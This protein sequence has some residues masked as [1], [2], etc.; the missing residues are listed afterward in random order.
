MNKPKY[1]LLNGSITPLL[2]KLST[3]MIVAFSFQTSFNFID[4]YFVSRLGDVSTAAIGMAF[5]IQL[6]IIALGSGM[7]IG[8]N[9]YISRNLGAGKTGR[10][11]Q[12]TLHSFLIALVLGG[13]ISI[14]GLLTHIY[15]FQLLGASGELLKAISEYLTIIFI[16]APIYLLGMLSNNIFRGWGDTIR[17]MKFMLTG[18]LLNIILDP[19]FIFGWGFIPGMGIKGA[20]LAT[21]I[22]RSIA[23]LYTLFIL[24]IKEIPIKLK[25]S[26][27]HFDWRIISGIFQVGFPASIG[28]ILTSF[29]I[30]LIFIILR[31][32]G[33]EARAAYTIAFTYE[34]IAF[35]PVIGIG[36]AIAIITGHNYGAQ[37][38]QRIQK[39]YFTGIK[40]TVAIMLLISVIVSTAPHFF[41]SVFARSPRVL[42]LTTMALRIM[43]PGY[44]FSGISLC[45][46]TS[47]QG[48]GLGKYQLMATI[49][50]IFAL[51]LPFAWIGSLI[52]SINGVWT[53]MLFANFVMAI[54]LLAWFRNLYYKKLIKG[55]IK[56]LSG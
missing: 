35:Q 33:D 20:A 54:F 50:R 46:T 15:I 34:M 38:Y 19:I 2:L 8:L 28:Q 3:P 1:D 27:I 53:G 44:L 26:D 36:Q 4:R 32:Y 42:Q 30:S 24:F 7:G 18:T 55:K 14:I 29:S 12:A 31:N 43:A 5:I 49:F 41:S 21:G 9:S 51:I 23:V 16:F 47:F 39:I 17:P 48:L 22:S 40:I 10:A 25:L 13:A 6:I 52:W 56:T 45:T 11:I 37:Q